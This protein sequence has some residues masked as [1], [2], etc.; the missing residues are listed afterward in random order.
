[1]WEDDNEIQKI[2]VKKITYNNLKEEDEE[3][4]FGMKLFKIKDVGD[5]EPHQ[6]DFSDFHEEETKP[7]KLNIEKGKDGY[8]EL[9]RRLENG[10]YLDED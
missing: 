1:M 7:V 10:V 2:E 4:K 3:H 8:L 6:V 5:R 9:V